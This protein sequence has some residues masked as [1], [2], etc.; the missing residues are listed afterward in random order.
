MNTSYILYGW[1]LSYFAGKARCY[2][3]YKGIRFVDQP[4]NLY[5]LM[6][7]IRRRTGVVVMPVL[8]TPQDE[9]LQDTSDI[10]DAMEQRFPARPVIPA[11]PIQRFAAYLF[12][13]WGDEWWVPIAM[14]TRWSYPE[15]Y[16]LFEREAGAHLLPHF[17]A[18]LQRKAVARV[19][20]SLRQKL[21]N[22][23]VRPE[24]FALLDAWT[25]Q[26][27]DMLERHFAA[28][29]Y[30][31]GSRPCLADFGLVGTMY[32]HLGRDPW[33]ARELIAPRPHLR[34]WIDRMAQPPADV[35]N[36]GQLLPDDAIAPTLVP[37]IQGL[38]ASFVPMLEGINQQVKVLLP[39]YPAGKALPRGL[40]DVAVPLNGGLFRRT[41]LPYTL[42]MAQRML[43]AWRVMPPRDQALVR[44]WAQQMGGEPLLAMDI[45]RLRRVGL[46]VAAN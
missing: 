1:H 4:V 13:A 38:L 23:G 28:Q 12:E 20:G 30:L 8:R 34:A 45:P 25:G 33:P 37:V 17:P 14:H 41:A 26:M 5:T 19:A 35:A 43:D 11:T 9:W 42:W 7:T 22:V 15:N 44:G 29:P 46:R 39:Q 10:I 27:L 18:A 21:H 16:P 24:Q 3:R 31:L 40:A 36:T 6:V 32:G 2:L